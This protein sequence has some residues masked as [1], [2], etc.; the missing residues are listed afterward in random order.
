MI[1]RLEVDVERRPIFHGFLDGG[2]R[3]SLTVLLPGGRLERQ[4]KVDALTS[5]FLRPIGQTLS[6]GLGRFTE[7]SGVAVRP[8]DGGSALG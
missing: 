5:A 8:G 6:G 1:D 4:R 7:T 2:P 3:Q